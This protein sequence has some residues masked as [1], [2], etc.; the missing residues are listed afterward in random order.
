MGDSD[1]DEAQQ[2]S[3][4]AKDSFSLEPKEALRD[5]VT[6]FYFQLLLASGDLEAKHPQLLHALT[7]FSPAEQFQLLSASVTPPAHLR[8]LR[9]ALLRDFSYYLSIVNAVAVGIKDSL[10][11]GSVSGGPYKDAIAIVLS[12]QR[13]AAA[14]RSARPMTAEEALQAVTLEHRDVMCPNYLIRYGLRHPVIVP[15]VDNDALMQNLRTARQRCDQET[16]R[17][18]Q[19]VA[20]QQEADSKRKHVTGRRLELLSMTTH[21]RA[22]AMTKIVG[23]FGSGK[24]HP[25]ASTAL[26]AVT[27]NSSTVGQRHGALISHQIEETYDHDPSDYSVLKGAPRAS[28][29]AVIGSSQP[30]Q[31]RGMSPTWEMEDARMRAPPSLKSRPASQE[32]APQPITFHVSTTSSLAA[33]PLDNR[34]PTAASRGFVEMRGLREYVQLV[35]RQREQVRHAEAERQRIANRKREAHLRSLPEYVKV[36]LL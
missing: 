27:I 24:T 17:R 13:K 10:G 18:M 30:H 1:L 36:F 32:C 22:A 23:R 34:N 28:G 6:R 11:E 35:D 26:P 31:R 7:V 14:G 8:T 3:A 21:A 2:D 29:E 15:K 4:V 33:V 12:A 9:D 20:E 5:A 19:R 25:E 16:S